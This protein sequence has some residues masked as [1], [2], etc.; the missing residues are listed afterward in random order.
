MR[1]KLFIV[2][3]TIVVAGAGII[4]AGARRT[5][6]APVSLAADSVVGSDAPVAADGDARTGGAPT[7]PQTEVRVAAPGSPATAGGL[8]DS[9]VGEKVI[10]SEEEWRRVLTDEQFHVM[11]E[12]G[13]ERAYT[14]A[15]WDN[16]EAGVYRCAGCGL[17]LF[18][19]ETKFDSQTG[20]PSFWSPISQSNVYTETDQ[21]YGMKRTEALCRRCDAHLGHIFDDGPKPTGLRYC[22]NS[23]S[24]TFEKRQ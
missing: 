20:W 15:L 12:K 17:A 7:G 14:G 18:N 23:A 16:H 6:D 8:K 24:L 4:L 3:C 1:L 19:S 21:S 2:S 9:T 13:T 10:K 11:R 5:P 22:I